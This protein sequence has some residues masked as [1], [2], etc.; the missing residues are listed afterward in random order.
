MDSESHEKDITDVAAI[1]ADTHLEKG[2]T[3][4]SS[5]TTNATV[6]ED[7]Q[8]PPVRQQYTSVASDAQSTS[9]RT[10]PGWLLLG[11][12]IKQLV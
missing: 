8:K 3:T 11:R 2:A 4:E 10:G 7:D 1:L 12:Q 9:A 6:K 5:A